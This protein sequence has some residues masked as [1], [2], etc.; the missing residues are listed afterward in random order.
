MIAF[1]LGL[2]FVAQ[3]VILAVVGAAAGAL[4]NCVLFACCNVVKLTN[5]WAPAEPGGMPRDALDRVPILGWWRL[6]REAVERGRG[7]WIGPL[8]LEV[9][10]TIA[11]PLFF[12]FPTGVVGCW[13]ALPLAARYAALALVGL[14]SGAFAN[15]LIYTQAH[16]PRPIDPWAPAA[17]EAPPRSVLD[18]IPIVGWWGLRRESELHGRGFWIRPILVEATMTAALPMLYWFETQCG[19]LLPLLARAPAFVSAYE[20]IATQTFFAHAILLLLMITAT[21]IDFDE[22]TIPDIITIPGT[23][24]AL[25]IASATIQVF[26]PTSL[27]V[28]A[29]VA[30][31]VPTTFDS[32]WFANP[33]RASKWFTDTGLLTG[34]GIWSVWCFALADRRFSG[35]MLRRRGFA[36]TIRFFFAAIVHHWTWKLLLTLWFAGAM[37]IAMIW[38][39]AGNPWLGLFSA[40]VGLAVGGGTIWAIRIVASWAMNMEAMGFGDVTLM[41]MI[42]AFIGWQGAISAF[43]LS[44]FAA[45][46]IVLVQY[47]LTRDPHVPFGPYLCAGAALTVAYWDLVYNDS[48]AFNLL[49]LWPMLQWLCLAMLGLMGVLLFISRMIKTVVFRE[50]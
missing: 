27:P 46:V 40:L 34:L 21:F 32:P 23:I 38:S 19:G 29:A 41:A 7:F 12:F 1:W 6:R 45:I 36:A 30:A 14:A 4:A 25:M 39:I 20:P 17:K 5:P 11:L 13:I 33:P 26:M 44:P 15:Y 16:L 22:K 48:L 42:G 43:F 31:V 35:V 8:V 18:R 10:T 28:G 24:I 2:P 47:I 49:T 50:S 9:A 37:F 3:I